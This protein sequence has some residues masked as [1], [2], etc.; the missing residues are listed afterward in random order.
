MEDNRLY[1]ANKN[2]TDFIEVNPLLPT[3]PAEQLFIAGTS[4]FEITTFTPPIQRVTI[5]AINLP[6]PDTFGPYNSYIATL[7]VIGSLEPLA[8]LDL[9]PTE[10]YQNWA[11]ST[12]LS[13]GGTIPNIEVKV[14]PTE[15]E[16]M[17]EI[18][19]QGRVFP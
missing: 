14:R 18:I 4:A 1:M 15:F 11:A 7:F 8:T 3:G 5:L 13:F 6:D 19:L 9:E 16:R 17:G 12:L 10:D 2:N